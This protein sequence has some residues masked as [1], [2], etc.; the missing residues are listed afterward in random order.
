MKMQ[1]EVYQRRG[2]NVHVVL[3]GRATADGFGA[4]P[5]IFARYLAVWQAFAQAQA[6]QPMLNGAEHG[7]GSW[8]RAASPVVS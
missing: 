1:I 3:S 2:G 7:A 5:D 6:P 8:F 4:D